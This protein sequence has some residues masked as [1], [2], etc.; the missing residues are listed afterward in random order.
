MIDVDEELK[1]AAPKKVPSQFKKGKG[2]DRDPR[3]WTKGRPPVGEWEK[4]FRDRLRQG[5]FKLI[6]KLIRDAR[7]GEDD[8]RKLVIEHAWGKVQKVQVSGPDGGP[9]QAEVKVDHGA[10]LKAKLDMLAAKLGGGNGAKKAE[11]DGTVQG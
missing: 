1:K 5:S 7:L 6:K 2:K 9:I 8:A 3:I 10:E 11:G 4:E